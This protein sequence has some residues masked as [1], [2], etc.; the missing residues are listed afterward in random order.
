[1]GKII[2]LVV[3]AIFGLTLIM[4]SFFT[5]KEGHVG[6]IT[7]FGKA[8]SQ[9]GPGLNFKT[10][11]LQDV[12]ELEV[13]EIRTLE[14]LNASSQ[15]QQPIKAEVSVLWS[16][17]KD[18]AIN[19]FREFKTREQFVDRILGPHMRQAA[20]AAIANFNESE[21]IRNRDKLA[22]TIKIK[23]ENS[24]A[25]YPVTV[26]S[27]QIENLVLPAAYLKAIEEK[28]VQEQEA[29]KQQNRLKTQEYKA[30]EQVQS[31][32]AEADAIKL[33]TDAQA[34]QTRER[35]KAE[36]DAIVLR[37][38]ATA[39]AIKAERQALQGESYVDLKA[40]DAWNGV[41]PTHMIP[42]STVPFIGINK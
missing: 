35:A 19:L 36:A 26:H 2:T 30:Q 7:R 1:M 24:L 4:G 20:K 31:A 11:F 5:V 38:N 9:V 10:P 34:Y 27:P 6:I 17:N 14:T 39:Q 21:L 29:Q 3:I 33:Q 15:S 41:V 8:E 40:V 37:G 12:E 42:Q 32:Q 28:Q 23:L 13:R 22:E 25:K 16:I 18:A